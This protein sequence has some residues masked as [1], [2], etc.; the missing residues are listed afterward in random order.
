M[1]MMVNQ[2]NEEK[3][4]NF[5]TKP[6]MVTIALEEYRDLQDFKIHQLEKQ[7][8]EIQNA[9]LIDFKATI[10]NYMAENESLKA[11]VERLLN[12]EKFIGATIERQETEIERLQA[13][14]SNLTS[15]LSSL[16]NDLSSAKAEIE[17]LKERLNSSI[18][19]DN[20][21]NDGCF[22]FD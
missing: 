12:F 19:I 17:R 4:E 2:I 21:K 14:N 16:Q 13:K 3:S 20:T 15:D 11:E 8:S 7:V 10:G 6:I 9:N 1:P 5:T 18:A 22:P